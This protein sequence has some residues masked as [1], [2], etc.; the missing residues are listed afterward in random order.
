MTDFQ[1][2]TSPVTMTGADQII[3]T[4]ANPVTLLAGECLSFDVAVAGSASAGTVKIFAD[5]TL[6]HT[7]YSSGA[8]GIS[9]VFEYCNLPG[10]T[11]V[12]S[13]FTPGINVFYGTGGA[14]GNSGIASSDGAI[15]TPASVAWGATTHRLSLTANASSGTVSGMW[16]KVKQ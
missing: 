4:G 2:T 3:Y 12:Q 7:I 16:W 11:T 1:S 10:S 14:L 5:S 13:R 8:L 9:E 15:S 6:I